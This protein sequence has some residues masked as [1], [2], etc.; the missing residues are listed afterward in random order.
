MYQCRKLNIILLEIVA[1]STFAS[2][3]ESL[4]GDGQLFE[5]SSGLDLGVSFTDTF[6]VT[7]SAQFLY[8]SVYPTHLYLQV[9]FHPF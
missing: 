6:T 5:V 7:A 9:V 3:F 1:K 8:A 4:S 2:C